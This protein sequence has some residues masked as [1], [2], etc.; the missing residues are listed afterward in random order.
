MKSSPSSGF[1]GL[2]AADTFD[3]LRRQLHHAATFPTTQWVLVTFHNF[4]GRKV[5]QQFTAMRTG[6]FAL[7]L[8]A[9]G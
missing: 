5:G 9:S 1:L 3:I 8:K 6:E 4:L 2:T 7:Y